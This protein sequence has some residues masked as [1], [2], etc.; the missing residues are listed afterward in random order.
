MAQQQ[1]GASYSLRLRPW[2]KLAH[3]KQVFLLPT[4]K[5]D[6]IPTTSIIRYFMRNRTAAGWPICFTWKYK[7]TGYEAEHTGTHRN[8]RRW[9][10][11]LNKIHNVQGLYVCCRVSCLHQR[12]GGPGQYKQQLMAYIETKTRLGPTYF[13][14]PTWVQTLT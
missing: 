2:R 4:Q 13:H 8:N 5:T 12:A 10:C 7:H 9:C 3:S 6:G 11:K 14:C 1:A